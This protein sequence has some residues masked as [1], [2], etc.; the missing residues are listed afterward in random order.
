MKNLLT[1]NEYI[2]E[3]EFISESEVDPRVKKEAISRLSQFFGVPS[4]KLMKFKFDGTDD[5]RQYTDALNATSYEGAEAYYKVAIQLAKDEFGIHESEVNE[6]KDAFV[7]ATIIQNDGDLKKGDIVK[8][9][10]LQYTQG[11]DNDK[12]S[13]IRGDGKKADILKKNLS[14]KI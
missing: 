10:A 2:N 1:F 13:I 3:S 6:A 4:S 5:V 12:I 9:N 14:V 7:N 8:V 11:G